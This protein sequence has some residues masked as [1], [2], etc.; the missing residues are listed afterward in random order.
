[1][2]EAYLRLVGPREIPWQGRPHFYHAAAAMRRILID[3]ARAQY[4]ACPLLNGDCNGDGVV[5]FDDIDTF[6]ALLS[7]G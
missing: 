4:P 2:H 1:V 5:N 6:V 7:G 3:R